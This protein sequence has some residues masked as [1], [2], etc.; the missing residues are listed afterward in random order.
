MATGSP[1]LPSPTSPAQ[2]LG[3]KSSRHTLAEDP[4]CGVR[5]GRGNTDRNLP[6][7]HPFLWAPGSRDPRGEKVSGAGA[8]EGWEEGNG[9]WFSTKGEASGSP[10]RVPGP[11]AS[12]SSGNMLEMQTLGP[13]LDP[14]NQMLSGRGQAAQFKASYYGL[15]FTDEKTK[16]E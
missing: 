7:R 10:S 4:V 9:H 15:H 11:A 6:C 16:A 13:T 8:W 12:A 3:P 5:W 14:L 2:A 1:E